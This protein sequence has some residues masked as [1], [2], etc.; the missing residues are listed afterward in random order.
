MRWHINF[1]RLKSNKS[2]VAAIEM[3]IIFP[4]LLVLFFG[5]IDVTALLSENRK[6]SYSA[7]AVA[8]LVSRLET[9]ATR[10]QIADAYKAVEV[11]MRS[12]N[13]TPVRVEVYNYRR[14]GG[15][16]LLVWKRDNGV[17]SACTPPVTTSLVNL[18]GASND[19]ILVVTCADYTPILAQ[20]TGTSRLGNLLRMREQIAVRPRFSLNLDCT[21]CNT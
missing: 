7:N 4:V 12:N 14:S 1:A 5:M 13:P 8:D 9:P 20:I 17:S 6:I 11:V 18:M 15:A 19:I 16:A 21:N 3:A 10:E 2:G